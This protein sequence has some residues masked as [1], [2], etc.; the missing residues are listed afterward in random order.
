MQGTG[1]HASARPRLIGLLVLGFLSLL[2]FASASAQV[3]EAPSAPLGVPAPQAQV[4]VA[5]AA[6]QTPLQRM[7]A[8]IAA[9]PALAAGEREALLLRVD[10]L[11]AEQSRP[12][13][14][15]GADDEI[16]ADVPLQPRTPAELD[17][18]LAAYRAAWTKDRTPPTL[19][20]ELQQQHAKRELLASAAS[21]LD[22]QRALLNL[23]PQ[24][25]GKRDG[26]E[27]QDLVPAPGWSAAARGWTDALATSGAELRRAQSVAAGDSLK[28]SLR[29]QRAAALDARLNAAESELD[30]TQRRIDWLQTQLPAAFRQITLPAG[31]VLHAALKRADLPAETRTAID[32][33]L[34]RL[35]EI[36][37]SGERAV[38]I[39][40]EEGAWQTQLATLERSL[41][42]TRLLVDA[43]ANTPG[44]GL[45]LLDELSRTVPVRGLEQRRQHL[46]EEFGR[47]RLALIQLAKERRQNPVSGPLP[48]LPV[49]A[50][51]SGAV[52]LS[53]ALLHEIDA[54]TLL[55]LEFLYGAQ[56]HMLQSAD[57]RL[58]RLSAA[59]TELR[60]LLRARLQWLPAHA[61]LSWRWLGELVSRVSDGA[62]LDRWSAAMGRLA[63]A[64]AAAPYQQL[65]GIA[66]VLLLLALRRRRSRVDAGLAALMQSTRTDRLRHSVIGIGW[67]AVFALP[68]VLLVV[69]VTAAL[70]ADASSTVV[71][72]NLHALPQALW[73]PLWAL[74]LLGELAHPTGIGRSHFRWSAAHASRLRRASRLGAAAFALSGLLVELAWFGGD[75]GPAAYESRLFLILIWSSIGML[76]WR[77]WAPMPGMVKGHSRGR[78]AMSLML[79]VGALSIVAC[80][81]SG[82]QFI[83]LAIIQRV[84][85]TAAIGVCALIIYG[86][87]ERWVRINQ[88]RVAVAA[89]LARRNAVAEGADPAP[90]D[91]AELAQVSQQASEVIGFAVGLCVVLALVALWS[92]QVPAMRQLDAITLWQS[93]QTIDGVV[94]VTRF[95]AYSLLRSLVVLLAVVIVVTKFPGLLDLALRRRAELPAGSRYASV[96]LFRYVLIAIGT[97]LVFASLGVHWAQLQWMAAALSVG[98]GFGM[99]EVFANFAAGLIVLFERPVRVGDVVTL[100]QLTGT[101]QSISTRAT[102]IRDFDGRDI[103][104]PNKNML[105]ENLVNWTL[106]DVS[107]RIVAKVGVAYGSPVQKVIELLLEAARADVRI[108]VE[109]PPRALFMA[110]GA[111]SLD[112]ELRAFVVEFNDRVDVSSDLNARIEALFREHEITIAFPQ[113]DLHLS[114]ESANH[115]A[116]LV[117]AA[118]TPL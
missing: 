38:A 36:N 60:E 83:G 70:R 108:Q 58:Q 109:P 18:D 25:I 32:A 106:S 78:I 52:S 62:I 97:L 57:S 29:G 54:H 115:A 47:V 104:V 3:A 40:R 105:A 16:S 61:P 112:F 20:L 10:A 51:E 39:S 87:A 111:S 50:I 84:Q 59:N 42:S 64:V 19:W 99:Q 107:T 71:L 79:S 113:L 89:A 17:A 56:L 116:A 34:A 35:D 110:F 63:A 23:A 82:Y 28:L 96:T 31:T 11:L 26:S 9:D 55:A 27:S 98:I 80:L 6:A 4:E 1:G 118:S 68:W 44:V 43:A 21:A 24:D 41:Q 69:L 88:R 114:A 48:D 30:L 95:T 8:E 85:Q 7:R 100:G 91:D 93:T 77:L 12:Q 74:A 2:A 102:T 33:T 101:V 67:A 103:V 75:F 46:L 90:R 86:L 92:D 15:A 37:E 65:T 45:L 81:V 53:D 5:P 117:R 94:S 66:L 73:L 76:A 72:E 22:R 49:A 14:A 13:S